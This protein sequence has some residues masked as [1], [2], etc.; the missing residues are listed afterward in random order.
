[1][2]LRRAFL[3]WLWFA[4]AVLPLW[5]LIGW[6]VFNASGWTFLWVLFIALPSVAVTQLVLTLL[7]RARPSVRRTGAVSWLDVAGFGVWHVLTIAVGFYSEAWFGLTLTLAIAAAIGVLWLQLWQLW[8]ESAPAR[9]LRDATDDARR[10]LGDDPFASRPRGAAP[11]IVVEERT[12]P[13]S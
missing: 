6:G 12:P 13:R 10:T 8:R 11:V 5:L 9:L 4:A 3:R 7:A 1:M 2:T